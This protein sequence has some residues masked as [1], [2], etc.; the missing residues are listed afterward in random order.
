VCIQY[1]QRNRAKAIPIA[2]ESAHVKVF[3]HH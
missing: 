2:L 3:R 1:Q